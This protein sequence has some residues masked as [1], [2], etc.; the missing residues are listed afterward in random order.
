MQNDVLKNSVFEKPPPTPP[1][2]ERKLSNAVLQVRLHQ[3]LAI[4]ALRSRGE[5]LRKRVL[6]LKCI[7]L[8]TTKF[9]K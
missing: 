6:P 8:F 1:K 9:L 2:E 7:G 3:K 5:D 4:T